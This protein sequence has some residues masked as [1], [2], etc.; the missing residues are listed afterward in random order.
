MEQVIS[1]KDK[2]AQQYLM[3]CIIQVFPDE[4]HFSTLP[5]LLDSCSKLASSVDVKVI[6]VSLIT[7]LISY[8]TNP[9]NKDSSILKD[10][11]IF[12]IFYENIKNIISG[13]TR[14]ISLEDTLAILTSLMDLSITCYP[15]KLEY[16]D[17]IFSQT[18]EILT[19]HKNKAE[20]SIQ[21]QKVV[22]QLISFLRS[23]LVNFNNILIV[24]QLK[25]YSS[26]LPF[27]SYDSRKKVAVEV[28]KSCIESGIPI[29]N[30]EQAEALFGLIEPLVSD[31]QDQPQ[32][33]DEEE[34]CEEQQLV[35]GLVHLFDNED[36][37]SLFKNYIISRR[38]FG[39]GGKNRI[40]YTLPPLIFAVIKFA[41]RMK[42]QYESSVKKKKKH[43][44]FHFHLLILKQYTKIGFF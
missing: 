18:S 2:I 12:P 9:Q 35:A 30:P 25:N 33:F 31:T 27:L 43:S 37:Q 38:F 14:E 11:E 19:T 20:E 28:L 16:V 8:V 26:L 32:E 21:N 5:E 3:E 13:E 36:L 23:P 40:K 1:C 29:P 7:R 17:S 6:I 10:K 42:N 22:K 34:F 24:L 44:N 39:K 41:R 15:S 4:Y